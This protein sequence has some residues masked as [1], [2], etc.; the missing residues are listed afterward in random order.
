M[1]KHNKWLGLLALT[2]AIAMVFTD[3]SVL[4]VALPT[5]QNEL[6]A[7]NTELWWCINAYLLVAALL[8]LAGGK[9]GDKIGYRRAFGWGMMIFAI[10][11][12]LCGISVNIGWLIAARALQGVGAALMIPA[13]S[14][15]LMSL[16]PQ[17]ERGKAVGINVSISSLFLICAPLIGGY[18]TEMHSWRWI[19]WINLPLAIL[20]LTLLL[21]FVP[22][23]SNGVQYFDLLGFVFFLISSSSLV[24]MIMQ[25]GSW[26]W[27]SVASAACLI[28]CLTTGYLL[29]RREKQAEHPLIDLSLFRHPIYKAV[30]ISIFATQFVL[31]ITIYRTV[32]VQEAFDWPPLKSGTI[33]FITSLPVLFMSAV[34]GWLADRSGS[35]TPI[36]IGFTLVILSFLWLAYFVQNTLW[37][38]LVGF[39]AFSFGIPLIFT[40]SYSSAMGAIPHKKAGTA[41][42]IIA[43]VRSFAA[44]LGVAF[45]GTLV[46]QV[47]LSS[48]QTSLLENPKTSNLVPQIQTLITNNKQLN[49]LVTPEQLPFVVSYM[50][51]SQINSFF[52]IHLLMGFG[53]IVA[54]ACVFVLY[55]RKASHH[56]P[57]APAE[58]WD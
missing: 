21:L 46:D 57:E 41:F 2:P 55:N 38:L 48:F 58:G 23:S 26:G 4:P 1:L 47:Q 51:K 13:S 34:G 7:T 44:S 20:G 28:L 33:F 15:L 39:F 16:F 19:F 36:A 54:F 10:A 5:I 37:I 35:K 12:A 8:L 30:N 22:K 42:G 11:S 43:T 53:L 3:Q 40:P 9:L 31:M 49:D 24:I 17:N 18:F 6:G 52:A 14:P 50:Q 27:I 29:F 32:F 25:G 45:I 56:L